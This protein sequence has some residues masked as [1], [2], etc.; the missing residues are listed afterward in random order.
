MKQY[1]KKGVNLFFYSTIFIITSLVYFDLLYDYKIAMNLG[2]SLSLGF[3]GLWFYWGYKNK[4]GFKN[5]LLVGIIGA[6]GGILL[7]IVSLLLLIDAPDAYGL[8]LIY[9]WSAPFTS[10]FE[11]I[12]HFGMINNFFPHISVILVILITAIGGY[13]G[14]KN[15]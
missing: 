1:L 2:I 7:V 6:S 11:S 13:L 4:L 15:E 9:P 5:G 10:L 12:P 14:K 3:L 8:W